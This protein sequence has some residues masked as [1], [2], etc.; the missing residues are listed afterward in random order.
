MYAPLFFYVPSP[1]GGG[2]GGPAGAP[3]RWRFSP[4][5]LFGDGTSRAAGERVTRAPG[6]APLRIA[7]F[8]TVVKG[9]ERRAGL[10]PA[11]PCRGDT[12]CRSCTSIPLAQEALSSFFGSKCVQPVTVACGGQGPD[13]GEQ[14]GRF[15]GGRESG[16]PA[17]QVLEPRPLS[18][19]GSG[20]GTR[21][22]GGWGTHEVR[23]PRSHP[24]G[25]AV[26]HGG[27]GKRRQWRLGCGCRVGCVSRGRPG[28]A[29]PRAPPSPF[30]F[31]SGETT[32][33]CCAKHRNRDLETGKWPRLFFLSVF[34]APG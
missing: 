34:P 5:A 23:S 26:W 9:M 24:R 29:A 16:L 32:S 10:V 28:A 11:F 20:R 21:W 7:L 15:G 22:V 25:C 2:V 12:L 17:V 31:L 4:C 14:S 8:G 1:G 27:F 30:G 33:Q 18:V 6:D 3:R 19:P 13:P